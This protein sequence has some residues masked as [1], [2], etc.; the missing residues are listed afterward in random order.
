MSAETQSQEDENWRQVREKVLNRDDY[1]CRFC[2]MTEEEHQEE[3]DCGLDVHHIIPRSDGGKDRMHNLAALCRSCHRTMESLHGQAME[4]LANANDHARTLEGLNRVFRRYDERWDEYDNLLMD[5]IEEN[6]VFRNKF[7]LYNENSSRENPMVDSHEL[8]TLAKDTDGE[9]TSEWE[10]ALKFGY[11]QGFTD[12]FC[13]LD[14]QTD[15]PVEGF[16]VGEGNE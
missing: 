8:R 9:I 4:E 16:E 13:D 1:E 2:G 6:P 10:C 5:F 15:V 3:T 14:G 7:G 12:V 11:L